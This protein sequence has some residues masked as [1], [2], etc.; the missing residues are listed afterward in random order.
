MLKPSELR[1][2]N[3]IQLNPEKKWIS[4]D[5]IKTVESISSKGINYSFYPEMAIHWTE[6]DDSYVG[7]PLDEKWFLIL[8]FKKVYR[9]AF[10]P[11]DKPVG[12][13]M[14]EISV[15]FE[16]EYELTCNGNEYGLGCIV[17]YVHQLQN[18][19][20]TLTGEE[21]TFK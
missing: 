5:M 6:L 20:F 12:F 15:N 2:G 10:E 11:I 4:S 1:I 21:L 8:G 17:K 7:V 14:L 19:Y 3:L 13:E 18:L 16:G 9:G